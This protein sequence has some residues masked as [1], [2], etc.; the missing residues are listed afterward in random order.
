LSITDYPSLIIP[1]HIASIRDVGA[2]LQKDTKDLE[3]ELAHLDLEISAATREKEALDQQL[4]DTATTEAEFKELQEYKEKELEALSRHASL[5]E[6]AHI[7]TDNVNTLRDLL[8]GLV[9]DKQYLE[10]KKMQLES[11]IQAFCK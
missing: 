11:D 7:P 4:A 2:T 5:L 6:N 1:T 9:R 10:S 8:S 3:A